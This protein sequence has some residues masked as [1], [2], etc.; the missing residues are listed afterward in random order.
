[1]IP[2]KVRS[3]CQFLALIQPPYLC[4]TQTASYLLTFTT[5]NDDDDNETS[6]STESKSLTA[7]HEVVVEEI[8][9]ERFQLEKNYTVTVT[10]TTALGNV[11]SSAAVFSKW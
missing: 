5:H 6:W 4:P 7:P 9:S 3:L 10:I 8:E 1:M 2:N 11:S